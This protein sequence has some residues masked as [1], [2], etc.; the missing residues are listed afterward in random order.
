MYNLDLSY[1][2][3]KLTEIAKFERATKRIYPKGT[4][5]IQI[6]A[7]RKNG[8]TNFIL[9]EKDTELESKYAV[10]I[11]KVKVSPEYLVS[12]LELA[13][14]KWHNKYVGNNINIQ[15][16]ALNY[17]ELD[18]HD[19]IYTQLYVVAQQQQ[20]QYEIDLIKSQI[21]AEK[22]LKKYFLTNMFI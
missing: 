1:R 21:E 10:I 8:L 3:I 12:V 6:S 20:L 19:D 16:E 5:A 17:F 15:M 14:P 4:I 18:Y 7:V 22:Q 2:H 11:P 9:L 13:E